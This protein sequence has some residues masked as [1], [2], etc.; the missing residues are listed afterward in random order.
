MR[1][2][3]VLR[4]VI[5]LAEQASVL[6]DSQVRAQLIALAGTARSGCRERGCADGAPADP[7]TGAGT[8]R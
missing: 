4:E 5:A 1:V 2:R 8:T 3:W 6:T 7:A